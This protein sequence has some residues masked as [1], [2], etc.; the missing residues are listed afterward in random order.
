MLCSFNYLF[1]SSAG[2]GVI[3]LRVTA[4]ALS[5]TEDLLIG[6]YDDGTVR[7]WFLHKN[8]L[9]KLVVADSRRRERVLHPHVPFTNENSFIT[10]PLK[11]LYEWSAATEII[12]GKSPLSLTAAQ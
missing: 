6:G 3:Q 8:I 12:S 5:S 2:D 4:L 1:P 9:K 7:I 11:L 10:S